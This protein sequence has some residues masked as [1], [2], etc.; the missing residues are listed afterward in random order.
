MT[1]D[2]IK[3]TEFAIGNAY[4]GG[5]GIAVDNP[6]NFPVRLLSFTEFIPNIN[7]V[8]RGCIFKKKNTFFY[9][10]PLHVKG[11]I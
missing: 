3:V 5:V 9:A 2:S 6:S 11:F 1:G 7:Q 8:G 10:Q 4:I